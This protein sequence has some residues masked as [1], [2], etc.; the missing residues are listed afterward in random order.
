MH[1]HTQEFDS[2]AAAGKFS[3][4]NGITYEGEW[5]DGKQDGQ[6]EE[7]ESERGGQ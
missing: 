4:S 1:P 2:R 3:W 5:K 7:S 6:G